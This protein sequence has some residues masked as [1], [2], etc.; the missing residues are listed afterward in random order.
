MAA[1]TLFSA[2]ETSSA[3]TISSIMRQGT[4][5]SSS[6]PPSAASACIAAK[7]PPAGDHRV[8]RDTVRAGFHGAGNQ[9][10]EQPVGGDRGLE[11]GEGRSIGRRL[12]HIVGREFELGQRDVADIAFGVVHIGL[13]DCVNAEPGGDT[14]FGIRPR[15]PLAQAL[16]PGAVWQPNGAATLGPC[17]DS[18][19]NRH[20][21]CGRPEHRRRTMWPGRARGQFHTRHE[22]S[23][24]LQALP[25]TSSGV[26]AGGHGELVFPAVGFAGRSVCCSASKMKAAGF[27]TINTPC[28]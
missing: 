4:G 12:A 1:R 26:P 3:A 16:A 2:S 23:G 14:L 10:L 6:S 27:V 22:L 24:M 13:R 18:W 20:R 21:S 9:V 7:P 17:M 19:I 5:W 8:A 11:L 25:R 28:R 15:P